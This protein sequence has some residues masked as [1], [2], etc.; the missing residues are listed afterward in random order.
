MIHCNSDYQSNHP[1]A[2]ICNNDSNHLLKLKETNCRP[3]YDSY[4]YT[5]MRTIVVAILCSW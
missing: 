1:I 5:T 2:I 3:F 4:C